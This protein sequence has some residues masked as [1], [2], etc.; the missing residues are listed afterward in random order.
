MDIVDMGRQYYHEKTKNMNEE[1]KQKFYKGQSNAVIFAQLFATS[2]RS[3]KAS[4]NNIHQLK[5]MLF[6]FTEE[7]W[8][9]WKK[10]LVDLEIPPQI[11]L[12]VGRLNSIQLDKLTEKIMD[13]SETTNKPQFVA[14]LKALLKESDQHEKFTK[15]LGKIF[16]NKANATNE[17]IDELTK[18]YDWW[19]DLLK[20]HCSQHSQKLRSHF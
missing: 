12:K 11:L 18:R 16:K 15:E 2:S 19:I 14:L 9:S 6:E 10:L 3:P 17:E 1:E 4:L 8:Q 20:V 5:P 7:Q 13:E